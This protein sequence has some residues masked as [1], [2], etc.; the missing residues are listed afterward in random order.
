MTDS[1]RIID[2]PGIG[3]AYFG[4]LVSGDVDRGGG[5]DLLTRDLG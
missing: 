2:P 5:D 3:K 1:H 4:G